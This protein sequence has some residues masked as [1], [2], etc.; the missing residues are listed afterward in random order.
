MYFHKTAAAAIAALTLSLAWA[1]GA[2][3]G[4]APVMEKGEV[5]TGSSSSFVLADYRT[6][7]PYYRYHRRSNYWRGYGYWVAPRKSG[8]PYGQRVM[9]CLTSGHPADFC[10]SYYWHFNSQ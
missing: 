4:V 5:L 9:N 3:S 2:M 10:Q 8:P 7:R 1:D 6:R